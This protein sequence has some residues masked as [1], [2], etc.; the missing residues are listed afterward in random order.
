VLPHGLPHRTDLATAHVALYFRERQSYA[1]I[2][3]IKSLIIIYGLAGLLAPPAVAQEAATGGGTVELIDTKISERTVEGE[4]ESCEYTYLLGYQDFIY[5]NGGVVVLRGSV[6]VKGF[7]KIAKQPTVILKVTGFDTDT[8]TPKLFHINYAYLSG[9]GNTY[10]NREYV[11]FACEDGGYCSG[12][13]L[14]DKPEI[15]M[16][17]SSS[18]EINYN[19]TAGSSDVTVPIRFRRDKPADSKKFD[20]C[21]L[22]GMDILL[23]RI[24]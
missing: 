10:S 13:T 17:L 11:K 12:Y 16:M 14:F 7:T 22:K 4:L 23:K 8:P 6:A 2:V 15:G 5:R 3:N 9:A 20:E 18:F 19:R 21:V 1:N 24:Q